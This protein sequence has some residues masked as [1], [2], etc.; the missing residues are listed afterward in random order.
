M[1]KFTS[2]SAYLVYIFSK[3]IKK[4]LLKIGH[5]I[6][7]TEQKCH[8]A[9]PT[10]GKKVKAWP[11]IKC[12]PRSIFSIHLEFMLSLQL[13]KSTSGT[14]VIGCAGR[15]ATCGQQNLFFCLFF[16]FTE[17]LNE[18]S[19]LDETLLLHV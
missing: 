12:R 14:T 10:S 2:F 16:T 13:L 19:W 3:K 15:D 7:S 17:Q 4:A 1:W 8:Q 9:A 18:T 6:T 5:F 11:F